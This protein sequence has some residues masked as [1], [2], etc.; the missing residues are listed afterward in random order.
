[1]VPSPLIPK[2]GI[3]SSKNGSITTGYTALQLRIQH[4]DVFWLQATP[5]FP[6]YSTSITEKIK[7]DKILFFYM[8]HIGLLINS[9]IFIV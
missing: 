5:N 9:P 8:N 7:K 1:M 3:S 6:V 2:K 4:L